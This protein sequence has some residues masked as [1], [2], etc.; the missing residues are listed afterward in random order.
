MHLNNFWLKIISGISIWQGATE[1]FKISKYNVVK[2]K[3]GNFLC[4]C[5][6][7]IIRIVNGGCEIGPLR[8][9]A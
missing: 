9:W 4:R 7:L 3:Y 1:R 5:T 8:I 2:L 6:V